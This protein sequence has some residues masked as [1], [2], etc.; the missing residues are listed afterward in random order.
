MEEKEKVK[1]TFNAIIKGIKSSDK[2]HKS[3]KSQHV[4]SNSYSSCKSENK[5]VANCI[6][7]K[8]VH[9]YIQAVIQVANQKIEEI[10]LF[11]QVL[12]QSKRKRARIKRDNPE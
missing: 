1:Y 3:Q 12:K 6:R 2:L 11:R 4:P 8:R 9:L 7:S 5:V 10:N